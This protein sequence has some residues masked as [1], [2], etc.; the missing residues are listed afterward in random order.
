[1]LT[2]PDS[3]FNFEKKDTSRIYPFFPITQKFSA[4]E[5]NLNQIKIILKN[6]NLQVS[7]K[8]TLEL[9]N[10]SCN[11]TIAKMDITNTSWRFPIFDRFS[12]P[13]ISDSRGKTYCLKITYFTKNAD[14]KKSDYPEVSL[15]SQMLFIQP[16]EN[17]RPN[18]NKKA[19]SLVMRPAYTNGGILANLT[20]LKNRISQDKPLFLKNN[21][22]VTL[23]ISFLT[24]TFLL[25]LFI[26]SHHSNKK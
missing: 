2:I 6:I 15:D 7:D 21:Y 23:F 26:I 11:E 5:N 9:N 12:F 10:E 8:I 17:T 1:M 14:I 16:F 22:L 25:L 3:S 4:S 24:L 18:F 20:T 19:S 13:A